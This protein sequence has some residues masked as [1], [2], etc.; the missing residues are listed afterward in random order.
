M[1]YELDEERIAKEFNEGQIQGF[2]KDL[3][4]SRIET[5]IYLWAYN[6]FFT[7]V[8]D[9]AIDNGRPMYRELARTFS[10][11]LCVKENAE[12]VTQTDLHN[13]EDIQYPSRHDKTAYEL[14]IENNKLQAE[15]D[16]LREALKSVK[17]QTINL[18]DYEEIGAI[19]TISDICDKALN[20]KSE[21]K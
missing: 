12:N 15:I 7:C 3:G 4:F 8:A 17:Q 19:A 9:V 20:G 13:I 18:G 11:L 16:R 5:L 1:I 10:K 2:M 14:K 6:H 21:G